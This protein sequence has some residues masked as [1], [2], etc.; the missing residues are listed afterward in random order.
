MAELSAE[1]K[2]K[3]EAAYNAWLSGPGSTE[4]QALGTGGDRTTLVPKFLTWLRDA[5][6]SGAAHADA[7]TLVGTAEVPNADATNFLNGYAPTAQPRAG[8]FS[9]NMGAGI[10]TGV[11]L[12][13]GNYFGG[14][15]SFILPILGLL[16]GG[17]ID[18]PNGLVGQGLNAIGLG[19]LVG[20]ARG[21]VDNLLGHPQMLQVSQLDPTRGFEGNVSA[22]GLSANQS[23]T[24]PGA[25]TAV[26]NLTA[27]AAMNITGGRT[28]QLFGAVD[29]GGTFT[30]EYMVISD[31][32]NSNRR[33]V[34]RLADEDRLFLTVNTTGTGTAA[35]RA[36][37]FTS[38]AGQGMIRIANERMAEIRPARVALAAA[39][40]R[41]AANGTPAADGPNSR[42][43]LVSAGGN[44][45]VANAGTIE[46]TDA[47][48]NGLPASVIPGTYNVIVRGTRNPADGPV[49]FTQVELFNANGTSANVR[50][51]I[52]WRD[53]EVTTTGSVSTVIS[54]DHHRYMTGNAPNFNIL[55]RLKNNRIAAIVPPG[56][57]NAVVQAAPSSNPADLERAL[58]NGA[59]IVADRS[60]LTLP[61]LPGMDG[62]GPAV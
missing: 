34:I 50:A 40:V 56:G 12:L 31:R 8:F 14:I 27:T 28:M 20:R 42:L 17:I 55:D 26:T 24:P 44:D 51:S 60:N 16:I 48:R 38:D 6:A 29:N 2:T 36:I 1:N 33:E 58:R 25:T 47:N 22:V 4:F 21:A 61:T 19:G 41:L 18:G 11:G 62:R 52:N 5:N 59:N 53:Q 45:V 57:N 37:D 3:L 32:G 43:T 23:L 54:T 10:L 30:P 46:I 15:M 35:T 49:T 39:P 9:S 7:R 13:A